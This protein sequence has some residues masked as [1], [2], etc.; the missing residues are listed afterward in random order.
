MKTSPPS[1][2]DVALFLVA[3]PGTEALV[4]AEA[5]ATLDASIEATEGGVTVRGPSG[6]VQ[7]ANLWLRLPTRVL[8][9]LG[10]IEARDF[11]KLQRG[12][13]KLPLA[14]WLPRGA[15]ISLRASQT[16]SRL[17]HTG[18]IVER[19]AETL[20]KA[21][22]LVT[23][24]DD[25]ANALVLRGLRDMFTV[26]LD[27]SGAL[28]HRRGWRTDGGDAPLRETLAAALLAICAHRAD[29]PLCD[30]MCGSGT[31]AIEG[32][33]R[34]SNRA[35]GLDRTF[36]FERF[37]E[38]DEQRWQEL[39][40]EARAR[41]VSAPPVFASDTDA[42]QLATARA[43]AERAGVTIEFEHVPIARARP[44]VTHGLLL[45][46]PPYG[47]RIG[48]DSQA[49]RDLRRALLGPFVAWRAAVLLP[50]R[51]RLSELGLTKHTPL[52][53]GGLRVYLGQR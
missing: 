25:D 44:R 52:S 29:E 49:L 33:L 1:T 17:F 41:I 40:A 50:D 22:G 24:D 23:T 4:E 15:K 31:I 3:A 11:G 6:L 30:P 16:R 19:A 43:N 28:L 47:K 45:T 14:R 53:N 34:A 38:H 8:L 2:T 42:A 10:D 37:V 27:T 39:R 18:A 26:S 21:F 51:A 48:G 5:R 32:A 35:P 13:G 12:L 36:A 9:R 20:S 46:N 7:R